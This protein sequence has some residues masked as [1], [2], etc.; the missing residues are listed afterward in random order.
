MLIFRMIVKRSI[1][2]QL[3]CLALVG[4]ANAAVC[5]FKGITATCNE[6]EACSVGNCG[7]KCGTVN[8]ASTSR[9]ACVSTILA[10]TLHL[11]SSS[12]AMLCVE[13]EG[14]DNL[15]LQHSGG[16]LRW[17]VNSVC[18]PRVLRLGLV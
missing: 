14:V 3:A 8:C 10:L 9:E 1:L 4:S 6:F 17:L 2:M 16:F 12:C 7:E 15:H 18:A 13:T 11:S 5:T